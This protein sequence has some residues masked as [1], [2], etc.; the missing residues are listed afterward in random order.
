MKLSPFKRAEQ[1]IEERLS[2]KVNAHVQKSL[3]QIQ[4]LNGQV[5]ILQLI[6]DR[7][8][9]WM[10]HKCFMATALPFAPG[11]DRPEEICSECKQTFASHRE[12]LHHM[13]RDDPE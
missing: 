9:K 12:F 11:E 8:Q 1:R 2:A 4:L 10:R 3:D 7:A 5:A 6:L 13:V